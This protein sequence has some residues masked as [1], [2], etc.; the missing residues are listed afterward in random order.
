MW[1]NNV[2]VAALSLALGIIG[3]PVVYLLFQN[4][5]NVG[6][7]GG[8][9]IANGKARPVLRADPPARPARADRRVRGCGAGLR[10]GW[11]VVDP[12]PAAVEALAEE[13]RTTVTIAIGSIGV[14]LLSGVIEAFVTPSPLPTWARITI[15]AMGWA[16]PRLRVG[17]GR[18]G[19]ARRRDRR[20]RR[21]RPRTRCRLSVEPSSQRQRSLRSCSRAAAAVAR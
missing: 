6:V 21:G 15:G 11:A 20:R 9:M 19:V 10:L 12:G 2:W 8:L 7:V 17:L 4:A 5:M 14:L 16:V 18:R 1:T 3:L 13:G